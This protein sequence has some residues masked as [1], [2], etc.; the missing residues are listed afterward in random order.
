MSDIFKKRSSWWALY[1]ETLGLVWTD[2]DRDTLKSFAL[3]ALKDGHP[4]QIGLLLVS[5]AIST[6]DAQKYLP[7]VERHILHSNDWA[8][9][10]YGMSCLVALG[11]CYMSSLQPRRAWMVYRRAIS[12]LQLNGLHIR[13][14][15]EKQELLFWQLFHAD[16][17]VSLM[18]GLPYMVPDHFCDATV[19][20]L[21][22]LGPSIWSYRKL[23]LVTAR[24]IDC[25]Q[26]VKGP[27]LS[28]ALQIEDELE[29]IQAQLPAQYLD[30][31]D[32]KA[33]ADSDDKLTRLYRVIHYYQLKIYIH[34]PF[35]LRSAHEA[36]YE[37]SRKSCIDDSRK[38]VEAYLEIFDA[39]PSAAFDGL[40]LNFVAFTATVVVLLGLTGYGRSEGSQYVLPQ[41]QVEH[42][43]QII[44][45]VETAL[46][47]GAH[48]EPAQL[49]CKKC[50][51]ALDSLMLSA[52]GQGGKNPRQ[53]IIPYFG[54]LSL[55][56]T[57]LSS[58]LTPSNGHNV[59]PAV[60]PDNT[61]ARA[62]IHIERT[63]ATSQIPQAPL[64]RNTYPADHA[65]S[66][67]LLGALAIPG[68]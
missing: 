30:L 53:V 1:R 14:K 49:L 33:C 47:E 3:Q 29:E 10:E 8:G 31:A 32:I 25:L 67:T 27:M 37:Y 56:R 22:Q 54:T 12:L 46:E 63:A 59:H 58:T 15:T 4:T 26:A 57:N 55:T 5:F 41:A 20:P 6:G 40:V 64:L 61:G 44:Y 48:T 34:L 2:P 7:P 65:E 60:R 45:R 42:D 18:I 38:L 36:K 13:R 21:S 23:G 62:K 16:R 43:W 50:F 51:T 19:A 9:S 68:V 11:L 35:L 28:V 52:L 17:W 66:Y 24:V 39:S